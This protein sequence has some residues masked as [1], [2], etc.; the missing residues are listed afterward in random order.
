MN[1][2]LVSVIIPT[3]NDWKR[4]SQCLDALSLQTFSKNMFEI[5]VSNNNPSDSAP[6]DFILPENSAII[7]EAS[8]GSYA[9]RNAALKIAK[10]KIIGFTDS[11]C[12]PDTNWIKNAVE[13]LSND[14]TCSRIAG[15]VSIF[16][17][18]AKPTIAELYDK[19][20]AFD[21]RWYVISSGTGVTANLFTYKDVFD[22]VGLFD[23]NL[24][25]GGDFKWGTDAHKK[26]FK[27][28]YVE[29]VIVKHP[30]RRTVKELVNKEKRVG[31]NQAIFLK[32]NNNAFLNVFEFIKELRPRKSMVK[33]V[34]KKGK[35]LSFNNKAY[36]L[37]LRHYLYFVRAY[38]KL[39][40]QTG[41][42]ANRA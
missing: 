34:L 4:L 32:Q 7:T 25:S 18:S 23:Q 39:Q 31:G 11:D 27:I 9:A 30:A 12:I 5:I 35:D 42:K 19:V 20:F 8:P 6:A 14:K 16:F 13:Y 38:A 17:Q 2:I 26:G 21:Q 37:L 40:V 36:I 3:Y 29:T 28:K 24:M 22:K 33:L 15:K 41:K 1:S 10:G